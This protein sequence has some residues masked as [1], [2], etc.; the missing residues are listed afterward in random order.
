MKSIA[1]LGGSR[2]GQG[3]WRPGRKVWSI[4]IFGSS[5]IDFCQAEMEESITEVVALTL[6]G[7]TKVIV[8]DDMPVGV[9][10]MSIL[11]GKSVNRP[12]AADTLEASKTRLQVKS[13]A[14]VGGFEATERKI[15]A[16]ENE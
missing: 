4:S 9:S 7:A 8:P 11:G 14:V 5:V 16:G 13:L 1:I 15:D 2:L 12:N 10:G 6:F 3:P